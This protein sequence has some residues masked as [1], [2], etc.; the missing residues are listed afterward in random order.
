MGGFCPNLPDFDSIPS[1]SCSRPTGG[2]C[3]NLPDFY[4]F[5]LENYYGRAH[6][7][8]RTLIAVRIIVAFYAACFSASCT[9]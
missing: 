5:C 3:P 9:S 1:K 4:S 8:K 6:I 7:A 2:S